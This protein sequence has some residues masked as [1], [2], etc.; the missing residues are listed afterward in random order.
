M[1]SSGSVQSRVLRKASGPQVNSGDRVWVWYAGELLDGTPFDANFN[2]TSF[3]VAP[4]RGPFP[5]VLGAGQ[6]I[7]GWEL[8][9]TGRHL[10][11]VLELTIPSTLAYG[12]IGAPPKIPAD[13]DLRFTV[14]LLATGN[15]EQLTFP[16][17]GD[18]GIDL[19][20]AG[21]IAADLDSYSF[22]FGLDRGDLLIGSADSD[23]LAGL[24][25][26]DSLSGL[27]GD[28]LLL[29]GRGN[30]RLAGGPG[31][32]GL[33]GS[34]GADRLTGGQGADQ[35]VYSEQTDSSRGRSRR[36]TITDFK[37]GAGDSINLATIDANALQLGNQGFR[38]IGS[39][40]FSG[41][42]G[43]ARFIAG[44]M[45]LNINSNAKADMEIMV[46]GVRTLQ[47]DV[48]VL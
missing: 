45:Q 4:A 32:D 43:E 20:G 23:G 37:G 3:S 47:A 29:G 7:Q 25:G 39:S 10:G 18:L 14:E 24:R 40:P 9:L 6:V 34:S 15:P 5:F 36:D 26:N 41:Q 12:S 30:D 27:D 28:D 16:T 17:F 8:A 22:K 2:F 33:D 48:L 13:A 1:S 19:R 31:N 11:E 21:A 46:S 42:P 38:F 44:M 35:F